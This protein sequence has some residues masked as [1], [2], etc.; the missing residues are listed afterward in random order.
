[1]ALFILGLLLFFGIHVL[2]VTP[3][4][5]ASFTHRL[6]CDPW[7]GLVAAASLL[8]I[9]LICIGWK[10]APTGFLFSPSAYV[11][12]AAPVLVSLAFV[13]TLMGGLGLKGFAR[14]RLRHPMVLGIAL[15]A[16]THLL[17]NGG[18]RE[19]ILFG[20]FL[21]YSLYALAVLFWS[22]KK[23]EFVASL[24]WD[25]MGIALGLFVATGL[26]HSHKLLFGVA[27]F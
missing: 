18:V 6:G 1:M 19:T 24:K 25:A 3:A 17:A 4:L 22:G 13:L 26:M 16:L 23:A 2:T 10:S 7:R 8:G 11:I 27:A 15:W 5:R 14:Q 9:V 12:K 20:G 21:L